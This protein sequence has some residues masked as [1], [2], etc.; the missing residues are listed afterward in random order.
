MSGFGVVD[1]RRERACCAECGRELL[2]VEAREYDDR[3]GLCD[4]CHAVA[5]LGEPYALPVPPRL[6]GAVPPVFASAR[7]RA[8]PIAERISCG[9]RFDSARPTLRVAS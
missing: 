4:E 2:P 8:Y 9:E 5:M 6:P 7:E 1:P 3:R